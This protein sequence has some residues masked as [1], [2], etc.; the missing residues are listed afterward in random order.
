MSD[1]AGR[2]VERPALLVQ[3]FLAA[4][5]VARPASAAWTYLTGWWDACASLGIDSAMAG[6]PADLEPAASPAE[7]EHLGSGQVTVLAARQRPDPAAVYQAVAY[8]SHDVVGVM[9]M[10]APNTP[11]ATW[12]DLDA[13][14]SKATASTPPDAALG[15]AM[16]HIG[17]LPR[18]APPDSKPAELAARLLPE[19]PEPTSGGWMSCWCASAARRS[20]LWEL[21]WR[22]GRPVTMHRRLLVVAPAD[23]ETELDQWLWSRPE[24]GLTPLTR[25]LLHTAK[26]RYE[27]AV[28]VRDLPKLRRLGKD[29]DAAAADLLTRV[30]AVQG[31]GWTPA[32]PNG[33][34]PGDSLDDLRRAGRGLSELRAKSDG[35][36][37]SRGS[38]A[39]LTQTVRFAAANAAAAI[40]AGF[41]C[42]AGGAFSDDKRLADALTTQVTAETAVLDA[43]GK[44]AAEAARAA[45]VTVEGYLR[46]RQAELTLIQTTVIGGLLMVLSAIQAFEY[47]VPLPGPLQAPLIALLGGL[48][49]ALPVVV[50]PWL[51]VDMGRTRRSRLLPISALALVGAAIGW[52]ATAFISRVLLDQ[53]AAPSW[54]VLFAG[55]GASV[56]ALAGYLRFRRPSAGGPNRSVRHVA[57]SG[58]SRRAG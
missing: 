27:H 21:P 9:I 53:L 13:E 47:K 42:Q 43:I 34:Q 6:L 26:V 11:S 38:L 40:G 28:L 57:P 19:L 46:D 14:W 49:L 16:V 30:E 33:R 4:D 41:E 56:A 52:L 18:D 54:T 48:A 2:A 10:L 36:I 29:V 23:R 22:D 20:T 45:D 7:D 55:I 17:L 51:L 44:Q 39:T 50:L 5:Q 8:R 32:R 31:R 24:P 25:Y 37:R 15:T 35:L 1:A 3:A 12:R 58:I